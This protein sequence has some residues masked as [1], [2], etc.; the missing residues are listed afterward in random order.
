MSGQD[1]QIL[2]LED[3]TL[4]WNY[5]VIKAEQGVQPS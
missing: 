4:C 1:E 2:V 3:G 5:E